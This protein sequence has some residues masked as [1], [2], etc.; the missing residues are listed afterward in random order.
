[1]G[2]NV[3]H[4]FYPKN[5]DKVKVQKELDNYVAHQDWQEGCTGLYKHIRWLPDVIC[6]NEDEAYEVIKRKDDGWYDQLAVLFYNTHEVEDDKMRELNKKRNEAMFEYQDRDRKLYA[7]TVKAQFI[8]CKKCGSRL[9]RSFLKSNNCPVCRTELRPEHMMK[10][11]SSAKNKLDRAQRAMD[12]YRERH[13]KKELMWLV[14]IE[15]HT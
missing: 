11:I 7:E 6:K 15:Y 9:A 14:K 13:G 10:S 12:E 3:E 1:M 5:V 4:F 2:H 8:G